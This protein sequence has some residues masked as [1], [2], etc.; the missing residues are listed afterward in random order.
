MIGVF[1]SSSRKKK[2]TPDLKLSS[3]LVISSTVLS[4]F[5]GF[6]FIFTLFWLNVYDRRT[7]WK[8]WIKI[9]Y[10]TLNANKSKCV[11]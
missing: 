2:T 6:A 8:L 5:N 9:C 7:D 10:F 4:F 1:R 3:R 11:N